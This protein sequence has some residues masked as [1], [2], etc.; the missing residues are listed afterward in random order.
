[1]A[2]FLLLLGV[3]FA[4]LPLRCFFSWKDLLPGVL[5]VLL[6]RE[7]VE[8]NGVEMSGMDYKTQVIESLCLMEW[9]ASVLTLMISMFM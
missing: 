7:I 2:I 9:P 6:E 1:M 3:L 5:N 8:N 4:Y